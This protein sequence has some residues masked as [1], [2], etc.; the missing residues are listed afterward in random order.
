MSNRSVS[1][2]I[3]VNRSPLFLVITIESKI[4]FVIVKASEETFRNELGTSLQ[5]G[6]ASKALHMTESID[7]G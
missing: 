7:R 3:R 1:H 6:V 4:R 2:S 5:E